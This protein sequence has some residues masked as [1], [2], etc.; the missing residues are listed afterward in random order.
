MLKV[1]EGEDS[2]AWK[3]DGR[4]KFSVKSYY[5][6]LRAESNFLFPANEIWGLC[7]PLRSRFF[8]WEAIW[9]KILTVD[10][11]MKRGWSMAIGA[12][13]VKTMRSQLT[14]F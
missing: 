8:A 3:N 4:G 5:K 6:S 13:F 12:A 1:Q 7:A 9:G 2:L 11:L 14:T 10:M